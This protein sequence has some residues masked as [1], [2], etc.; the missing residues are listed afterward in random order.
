MSAGEDAEGARVPGLR[1]T[2]C[3]HPTAFWAPCCPVCR[4]EVKPAAFGPRGTVW[5]STVVRVPVAGLEPPY[6]LAYVDL[7]DGPRVLVRT[8]A[9]S[10]PPGAQVLITSVEGDSVQGRQV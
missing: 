5:S 8:I 9:P 10:P 3:G 1:C 4:G 7:D 6:G 2:G